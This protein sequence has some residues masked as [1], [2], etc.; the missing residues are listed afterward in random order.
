VIIIMADAAGHA[1]MC[2]G[3]WRGVVG[4]AAG[5]PLLCGQTPQTTH[6]TLPMA[7]NT[8]NILVTGSALMPHR[9]PRPLDAL[10]APRAKASKLQSAHGGQGGVGR[11]VQ[12]AGCGIH[13]QTLRP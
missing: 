1:V 12:A 9:V 6:Q 3:P 5:K 2:V 10:M 4:A 8:P 11:A 7:L 13:Q